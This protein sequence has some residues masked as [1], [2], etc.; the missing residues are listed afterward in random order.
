MV[1][2]TKWRRATLLVSRT[3]HFTIK[4]ENLTHL[5]TRNKYNFLLYW[6]RIEAQLHINSH[7]S[8]IFSAEEQGCSQTSIW[9]GSFRRKVDLFIRHDADYIKMCEAAKHAETRG[10]WGHALPPQGNILK[11]DTKRLNLMAFQSIKIT[12]F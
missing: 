5:H 8:I 3:V 11:I 9:V 10:L 6:Y 2:H 1:G 4:Q 7:T 12:I